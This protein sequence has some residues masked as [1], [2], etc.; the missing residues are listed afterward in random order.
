MFISKNKYV[1]LESVV[2]VNNRGGSHE[3]DIRFLAQDQRFVVD[4]V[5]DSGNLLSRLL[6]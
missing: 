5:V 3:G 6:I 2:I 4:V 1:G